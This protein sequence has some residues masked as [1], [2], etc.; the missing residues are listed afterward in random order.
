MSAETGVET[1]ATTARPRSVVFAVVPG[2]H[3]APGED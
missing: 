3:G 2:G 1:G